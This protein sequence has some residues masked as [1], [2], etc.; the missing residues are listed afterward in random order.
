MELSSAILKS[1]RTYQ[2]IETEGVTLWPIRVKEYEEFLTASPAIEVIQQSLPAKWMSVPLLQAF[3]AMAYE[4]FQNGENQIGLLSKCLLFLALSLRLG[5]G[6]E[7]QDRIRKFDLVV[8]KDD[9]SKLRAIR[10]QQDGQEREIT[11]I[12]FYRMRLILAAQNGIELVSD[13]ANP[14]LIE[15]ERDLAQAN[16]ASLDI[17]IES[18]ISTV[19]AFS[20]CQEEEIDEWPILKM[21]NR[22]KAYNR[23]ADYLIYGIGATQGTKYKGG[24]P[25]PNLFYDKK[26][27][28]SAL[29]S[30]ESFAGKDGMAA[31]SKTGK[32]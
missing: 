2:P 20:S 3:Y 19:A 21:K 31:I 15:A 22:Q 4:A 17:K 12:T 28:S 13:N 11:P 30:L 24:N 27:S 32:L 29:I 26:K 10:F 9:E 8:A 14:E 5:E 23:M 25:V 1:I 18:L 7:I 16:S 6:E